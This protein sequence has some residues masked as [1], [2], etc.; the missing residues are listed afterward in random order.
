MEIEL[1]K[2][3]KDFKKV[4]TSIPIRQIL[5][6]RLRWR[7]NRSGRRSRVIGWR[8]NRGAIR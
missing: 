1:E 5:Q 4:R 7:E 6:S 3:E 2:K 8:E